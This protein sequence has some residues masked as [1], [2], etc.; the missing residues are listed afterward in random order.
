MPALAI[1]VATPYLDSVA[2]AR[3]VCDAAQHSRK[4]VTAQ[5]YGGE[6]GRRPAWHIFVSAASPILPLASAR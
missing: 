5:L 6:A 4:A 3:G 2:L 1:N